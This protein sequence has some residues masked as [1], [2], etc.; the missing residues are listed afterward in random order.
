[1]TVKFTDVFSKG[2]WVKISVLLVVAVAA[3]SWV[4]TEY[5]KPILPEGF[6]QDYF[7]HIE[8]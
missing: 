4:W 8:E 7:T 5:K 2:D 6:E 1:M 3:W